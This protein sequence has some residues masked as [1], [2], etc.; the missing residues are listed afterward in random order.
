M[1]DPEN[2]GPKYLNAKTVL[3]SN[4]TILIKPNIYVLY[5]ITAGFTV[6]K[7]LIN[8]PLVTPDEIDEAVLIKS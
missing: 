4:K 1:Y 6:L 3:T 7:I 5:F 8:L 2:F